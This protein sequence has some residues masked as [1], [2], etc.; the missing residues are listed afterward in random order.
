MPS[1]HIRTSVTI[2]RAFLRNVFVRACDGAINHWA[3]IVT[4]HLGPDTSL[5]ENPDQF[6]AVVTRR[7]GNG[8]QYLV[9]ATTIL[10]GIQAIVGT[11]GDTSRVREFNSVA[12]IGRA[13]V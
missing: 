1:I 6:C 3:D 11:V 7:D 12:E 10:E 9:N 8:T 2:T 4:Y 5:S 13:H